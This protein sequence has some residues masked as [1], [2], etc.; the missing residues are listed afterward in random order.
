MPQA[1][2]S[3][4]A[5]A[6]AAVIAAS[7]ICRAVQATITADSLEK[8][9]KSPVTIADYASQAVIC[10]II[11]DAFRNDP[12]VG[13]EDA[14]DLR[15]PANQLFRDR[16]LH[17]I[18]SS[19]TPAT[20]DEMLAWI[21]S[22]NH[23][24]TANRYWTLD[25][26]DGTKGFL[27]K[28]QFAVSLA[29]LINKRI[30]VAALACPNL[31]MGSGSGAVFYAVRGQG[32]FVIPLDQP[33]AKPVAVK[34][35]K[36]SDPA[37]ARMC[38]SVESGHSAHDQSAIALEKLGIAG[39]PVRMDSQA[40]YGAVARGDAEIYLRLPTRKGYEEKI[41][42]HAGG[43]LVLEEAG[44]KVTDIDGH[45]LD[46]AAGSTLKNNRGVVVTNGLLHDAVMAVVKTLKFE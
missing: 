36:I 7:K 27:R 33:D 22:G 12:I 13:E 16:T 10:K 43:V 40:K 14:G 30:E 8:K 29:L 24:G 6:I 5:T 45:P 28:E 26:I 25:P 31:P 3:E 41:W 37:Q 17:E 35:S 38:E 1:Y 39:E 32:A 34:V 9:D 20:T 18:T 46:F 42:D 11:L 21:D 15:E 4:L 44:G 19:G 23:D 2:Q